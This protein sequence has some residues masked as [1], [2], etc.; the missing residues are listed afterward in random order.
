[1][2]RLVD[3]QGQ[4]GGR[5]P[6]FEIR[7]GAP[8]AWDDKVDH[9]FGAKVFSYVKEDHRE[10]SFA[11]PGEEGIWVGRSIYFGKIKSGFWMQG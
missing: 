11:L 4:M 2:M 7:N 5:L 10:T 6:A 8:Y 1:M 3:R 9:H